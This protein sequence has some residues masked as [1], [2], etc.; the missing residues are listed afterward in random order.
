MSSNLKITVITATY[1]SYKTLPN[2]FDSI[3]AQDFLNRE[4]IVIDNVSTDSTSEVIKKY[5]KNIAV[6]KSEPDKGIYD[7]LNKGLSL[8]TGDIVGFLHADDFYA[9]KNVLSTIAA[10]FED[11]SVCAVYGDLQ[12]VSRRDSL[13]VIR[14]WK[15]KPFDK[16]DLKFGWMPPH[17]TLYVRREWYESIGGFDINYN[18]SGD[19]LSILKLF[20]NP[21]F[22]SVY[23]PHVF[24]NM[25]LGG[26]SNGSIKALLNKSIEDWQILRSCKF[27]VMDA[28]RALIWK[29]LRKLIQFGPI[30]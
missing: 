16:G 6:F 27:G 3:Y 1:N 26:V 8:A 22:N 11:K 24:V 18:V 25:R 9:S 5:I 29:N 7:A 30:F 19:Y 10:A 21:E 14:H 2:C 4:H 23:L 17:P 28:L 12:Y 15:S 13:K 20:G